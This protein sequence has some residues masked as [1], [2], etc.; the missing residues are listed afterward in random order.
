MIFETEKKVMGQFMLPGNDIS[1]FNLSTIYLKLVQQCGK[2][3]KEFLRLVGI[4]SKI[5]NKEVKLPF[6]TLP[7]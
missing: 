1:Y 3:A 2:N 7:N 4:L 6:C 5:L